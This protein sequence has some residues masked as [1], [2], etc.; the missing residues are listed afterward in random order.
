MMERTE[1]RAV[2]GLMPHSLIV[3][4]ICREYFGIAFVGG[5][6]PGIPG[7]TIGGGSISPGNV[8][9][10]GGGPP[11]GGKKLLMYTKME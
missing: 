2:S 7:S 8:T 10:G 4:E 6:M 5:S 3:A 11:P 9:S 1:I